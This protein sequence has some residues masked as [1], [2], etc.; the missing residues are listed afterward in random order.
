MISFIET[1]K[2]TDLSVVAACPLGSSLPGTGLSGFGRLSGTE[3]ARPESL[4]VLTRSERTARPT[5]APAV[6]AAAPAN[7]FAFAAANGAESRKQY[8]T[9]DMWAHRG[10]EPWRD[11]A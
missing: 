6:A 9:H 3:V 10:L 8:Q 4:A 1:N 5:E 7:A 11:P 2:M